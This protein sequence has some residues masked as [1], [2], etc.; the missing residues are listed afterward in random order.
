MYGL[1]GAAMWS[2]WLL[3]GSLRPQKQEQRFIFIPIVL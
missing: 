3:S 2:V 1:T